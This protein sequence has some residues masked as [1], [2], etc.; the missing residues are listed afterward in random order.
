VLIGRV[1]ADGTES[2][3]RLSTPAG[4]HK[5]LIDPYAT[6]LSSPK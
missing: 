4:T 6:I 1:F 5:L 2:M 3:F